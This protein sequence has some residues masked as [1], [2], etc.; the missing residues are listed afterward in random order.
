M[1]SEEPFVER[2]MRV[3]EDRADRYCELVPAT[4]ALIQASAPVGFGAFFAPQFRGV[5]DKP[6][7]LTDRTIRPKHVLQIL[8]CVLCGLVLR[9]KNSHDLIVAKSLCFVKCIIPKILAALRAVKKHGA[10]ATVVSTG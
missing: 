9:G 3:F 4:L 7:R 5:V 10:E 8:P 2:D 1:D 6:A